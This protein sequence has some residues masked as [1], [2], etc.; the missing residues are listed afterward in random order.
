MHRQQKPVIGPLGGRPDRRCL[1][2][3]RIADIHAGQVDALDAHIERRVVV[4]Q[5]FDPKSDGIEI[6]LHSV[7][8]AA[9]AAPVTFE[10]RRGHGIP[11]APHTPVL[12]QCTGFCRQTAVICFTLRRP[13]RCAASFFAIFG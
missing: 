9:A 13:P 7:R 10:Q 8:I 2:V 5:G 3:L 11:P 1:A 4:V 12:R 6:G